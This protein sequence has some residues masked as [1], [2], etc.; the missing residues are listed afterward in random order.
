MKF[1][2]PKKKL[3]FV[4]I[5]EANQ[6]VLRFKIP[7][8][9]LY[10]IAAALLSVIVG[11]FVLY[12]VHIHTLNSNNILQTELSEIDN[13]YNQILVSKDSTIEELQNDVI[14]LSNQADEMI[15]KV[16]A[17]K[18]LETEIKGITDPIA[19][20][21]NSVSIASIELPFSE[22]HETASQSKDFK[23]LSVGG[24]LINLHN[25]DI[26]Q[27]SSETGSDFVHLEQEMDTLLDSL[28]AAKTKII[29]H[30][31]IIRITPSIWPTNSKKVT[32]TFGYRKDPFT[33]R[34]SYHAGIDIG[35][36]MNDPVYTTADGV[37][38]F[39]GSDNS[40]GNNVII[41]HSN[42]IRTRYMHLSKFTVKKGEK[43]EKGQKIGQL[44]STGRSTGPHLHYEIIKNGV[45]IDPKP[46]M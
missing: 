8:P 33:N 9:I 22:N 38:S 34:P 1:K 29:E 44:G 15:E 13:K 41:D 28:S 39:V 16:E 27:L 30:Q 11:L 25:D 43:V 20:N 36:K 18:K 31:K 32:S 10:F 21:E 45:Q 24:A 5:P 12:I 35:G 3:T 14:N 37:V 46:Y 26:L 40:H 2:W 42:G 4:I 7:N 6:S 23:P 19:S 17:L